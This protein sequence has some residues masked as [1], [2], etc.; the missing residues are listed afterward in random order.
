MH[1]KT[2]LAQS[3]YGQQSEQYCFHLEEQAGFYKEVGAFKEALPMFEKL[4]RIL[5]ELNNGEENTEK[6]MQLC[7]QMFD[8]YILVGSL[9]EDALKTIQSA[10]SIHKALNG[11][12]VED[13]GLSRF[14]T[15]LSIAKGKM[16]KFDEALKI[17]SDAER[18]VFKQ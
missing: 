15:K 10:I 5:V 9:E 17:L 6:I 7:D 2:E 13:L 1:L 11:Q 18:I 8:M 12:N 14:M 16:N 4:K 3:L